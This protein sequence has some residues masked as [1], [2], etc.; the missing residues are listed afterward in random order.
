VAQQLTISIS[1]V[2]GGPSFGKPH[3]TLGQVQVPPNSGP[4]DCFQPSD[5]LRQTILTLARTQI[6]DTLR[7]RRN[8]PGPTN[9]ERLVGPITS[10]QVTQHH[11]TPVQFIRIKPDQRP[12]F[13][14]HLRLVFHSKKRRV[15]I[16]YKTPFKLQG[17]TTRVR[18]KSAELTHCTSYTASTVTIGEVSSALEETVKS[19]L[20]CGGLDGE[21]VVGGERG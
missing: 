5:R 9:S 6:L 21:V 7:H 12:T 2:G 1:A 17:A 11:I 8:I 10:P 20:W 4:A 3:I 14:Q 13:M 18:A 19:V 15:I 16:F